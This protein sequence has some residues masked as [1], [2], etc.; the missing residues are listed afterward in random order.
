MKPAEGVNASSFKEGTVFY[1]S[2]EDLLS[3]DRFTKPQAPRPKGPPRTGGGFGDRGRGGFSRGGSR[4]GFNDRGRGG[5][6]RGAP[7]GRGS[8]DRR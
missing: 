2:P 4:G 5:F 7:R 3:T 8:F 1:M 6:S